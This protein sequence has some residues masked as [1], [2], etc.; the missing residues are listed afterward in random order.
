MIFFKP[1]K[2]GASPSPLLNWYQ[3]AHS[4]SVERPGHEANYS[5]LHL[6][7]SKDKQFYKHLTVLFPVH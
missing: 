7:T 1:S 4:P 2:S 5:Y 6:T 3:T